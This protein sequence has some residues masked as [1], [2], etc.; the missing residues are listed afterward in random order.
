VQLKPLSHFLQMQ[1]PFAFEFFVPLCIR[2]LPLFAAV[3]A[4]ALLVHP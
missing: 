4:M 2:T 1:R 3:V